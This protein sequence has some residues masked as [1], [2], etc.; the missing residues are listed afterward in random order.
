MKPSK[1]N[2]FI[3]LGNQSKGEYLL[4]N[5]FTDTRARVN[6]SLKTFIEKANKGE[7]IIQSNE[8]YLDQLVEMGLIRLDGEDEN[9]L[10]NE[11]LER[12]RHDHNQLNLT[13]LTTYAC[14][15]RCVYCY[16]DAVRSQA[17][18]D[19]VTC[20]K[21]IEW[22]RQLL[23]QVKPTL[24]RLTFYGGEPLLNIK[25]LIF[26]AREL[27]WETWIRDITQEIRLVTNGVLLD[28]DLIDHLGAFGLKR[29]KVTLD[30]DS[31][32]HDF[33][34]PFPDGRG[35]FHRIWSNLIK[36][37]GRVGLIIG[38]N[39]DANSRDSIPRLLDRLLAE[40]FLGYVDE[41][42]FKPI[43]GGG[44]PVHCFTDSPPDD[45]LWL[46]EETER[47][48]F[49]ATKRISLGPCDAQKAYSFTIDPYGL[50]YKCPAFVGMSKFV[51]GNIQQ[52][53]FN[54]VYNQFMIDNPQWT[55]DCEGCSYRPL[56]SGGCRY[57]AYL[58]GGDI[59]GIVCER[60]YLEKVALN[61]VAR[62][63]LRGE[64]IN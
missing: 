21:V 14:N 34:R 54:H 40:G 55:A 32:E 8:F 50:I 37:K 57:S 6:E 16:Q 56:C 45:F 10:L 20:E 12:V 23:R 58:K 17:F 43:L 49:Q 51:I 39:Y 48:G 7:P 41:L 30:G 26:L 47:R 18:M 22:V 52:S 2:V 5:T 42:A 11:W 24:L 36:I 64:T 46:I 60:G 63:Y 19:Q 1:F 25:A 13:L 35:S 62:D 9:Q 33:Y 28:Q 3:P 61:L 59:K 15:L 38:G 29:V 4:F 27:F 31:T 44:R 53:G